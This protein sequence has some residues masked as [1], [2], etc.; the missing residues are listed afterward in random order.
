M[1]SIWFTN[2]TVTQDNEENFMNCTKRSSFGDT[3]D[4]HA[5]GKELT[6]DFFFT[7]VYTSN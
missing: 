6:L 7:C 4:E 5:A 3:S 2:P 1:G